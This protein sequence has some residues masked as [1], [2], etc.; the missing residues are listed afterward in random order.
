M[1]RADHIH[2]AK[3]ALQTFPTWR[4]TRH[5]I[6][7]EKP[8]SFSNR[9]GQA[10]LQIDGANNVRLIRW[11]SRQKQFQTITNQLVKL[12]IAS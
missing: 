6:P 11:E 10:S 1:L 7:K 5:H 3:Y 2:L 4:K 12:I 8:L 9:L